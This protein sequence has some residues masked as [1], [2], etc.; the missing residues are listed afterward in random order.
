MALAWE[1]GEIQR[2]VDRYFTW[3]VQELLLSL[4]FPLDFLVSLQEMAIILCPSYLV[5][6]DSQQSNISLATVWEFCMF[7]FMRKALGII[8]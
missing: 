3:E 8:H 1:I 6:D 7:F 5:V 2:A 4:L